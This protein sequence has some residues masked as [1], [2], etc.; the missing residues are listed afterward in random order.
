MSA[1]LF[2]FDV[3]VALPSLLESALT[4]ADAV[5]VSASV[6]TKAGLLSVSRTRFG[7]GL[8]N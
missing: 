3:R 1:Y 6:L 7:P 2:E 8:G 5:L 4:S